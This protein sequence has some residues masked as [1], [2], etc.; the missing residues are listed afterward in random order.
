MKRTIIR[1][2]IFGLFILPS[3]LSLVFLSSCTPDLG[4]FNTE[5]GGF[6][7]YYDCIDDLVGKYESP[8]ADDAT[9]MELKNQTYDLEDSITNEYI[10]EHLDWKDGAEKVE[11]R[12][13]IYI[14]VPF[15]RDLKVESLAFFVRKDQ[16]SA[17]GELEFSA[18]YFP[19]SDSCPKDDKLK[20][21]SDPDTKTQDGQEVVIEY[22]DPKKESRN[23]SVS[24][25]VTTEFDSFVMEKF[26]QTVDYGTSYVSDGCLLAKKGSYLYL[27]IENN[28][29]LDRSRTPISIQFINLLVRAI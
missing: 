11:F 13:Y 27:R 29:A 9:K 19:N 14:V 10:M 21:S 16:G 5:N 18:F 20:K 26:H 7:D 4:Q 2:I 1:K 22:G 6:E 28:S 23:A 24:L 12:Q 15:N 3:I 25:Y 17:S 8:K